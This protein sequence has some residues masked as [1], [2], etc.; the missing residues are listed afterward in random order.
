MLCPANEVALKLFSSLP[1]PFDG[2]SLILGSWQICDHSHMFQ[3]EVVKLFASSLW[4]GFKLKEGQS[5]LPEK[6]IFFTMR[7]VRP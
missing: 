4:N 3:Q 5:S 1:A 7:V 2:H 6:E